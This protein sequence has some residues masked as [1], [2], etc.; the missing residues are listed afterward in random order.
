MTVGKHNKTMVDQDVDPDIHPCGSSCA[1]TAQE[2]EPD[3]PSP[4]TRTELCE[5]VDHSVWLDLRMVA[6]CNDIG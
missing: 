3:L 5:A 6:Q 2:D 1:C 4:C